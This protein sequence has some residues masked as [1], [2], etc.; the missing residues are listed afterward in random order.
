MDTVINTCCGKYI[1][2]NDISW[3]S[4]TRNN[5]EVSSQG[6]NHPVCVCVLAQEQKKQKHM[7]NQMQNYDDSYYTNYRTKKPLI[8]RTL[9]T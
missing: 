5:N 2:W 4:G 1:H 6:I 7:N 9:S 3:I 8:H